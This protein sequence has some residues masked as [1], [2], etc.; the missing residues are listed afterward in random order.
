MRT[1]TKE[2][3]YR[4]LTH[5]DEIRPLHDSILNSDYCPAYHIHPVTGLLNDPN[6]FVHHEGVWHLFYQWCP[7]GAVHGLK[8]WYHVTSKDLVSWKN[9]GVCIRPD[10]IYDNKGA[11]SGSAL[12]TADALYLYY[13]GNHRDEDWTRKPYTCL[14]ELM[15]DGR[16]EKLPEPLFGPHPGYTEHQR[17][18][19]IIFNEEDS[20]Y[21]LIIGAQNRSLHGCVLV[22]SSQSPDQDWTFAGELKVQGFEA[23]GDMWECPSIEKINGRDVLIFCPQHL[24]LPGRGGAIHHSGYLI[25]T[26][27]FRT[28]TFTPDGSFHVLDFGFDSYA[29]E[30]AATTIQNKESAVLVAWMGYPDSAYP[31]DEENWQGC[32]TLPRE[33]TVRNRRLI[34]KPLPALKTLRDQELDLSSG[35][36]PRTAEL[37]INV[38][39]WDF[40]CR[41]FG[42][43]DHHGSVCGGLLIS[44]HDSTGE[45]T[46]DRSGLKT[47]FEEYMGGTRTRPLED[48]L[49]HLRIFID[50]SSVEIFV[51]DGDAVFTTR[52]FPTPEENLI[53]WSGEASLRGW[54]IRD[55]VDHSFIV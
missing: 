37:E 18:P 40:E 7:W 22:Y 46:I 48:G 12:P 29:A 19:K 5:S 13:T 21:Y 25:G 16:A 45:I 55:A 34:Q 52:V 24:T 51:N 3:R 33:L 39:G 50:R 28:L 23:F 30:C 47:Q 27:D 4:V 54:T 32:L 36:M 43:S 2:E 15:D 1:W 41:L 11:Y 26:M 53:T 14:V 10:R 42:R 49:H 20:L 8:Y 17:D 38:G 6:G 9:L 31:T 44:Y 35:I